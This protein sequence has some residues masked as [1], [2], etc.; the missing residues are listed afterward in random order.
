MPLSNKQ[1]QS[2]FR[3]RMAEAGY[4]RK[5]YWV[6]DGEALQIKT[7]LRRLRKI[8]QCLKC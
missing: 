7:L 8:E 1:K 5:E 2:D 4:K 3:L 6:T